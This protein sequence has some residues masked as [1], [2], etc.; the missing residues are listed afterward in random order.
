MYDELSEIYNF[1]S[2]KLFGYFYAEAFYL[3]EN[4]WDSL[5]R[6]Q[7]LLNNLHGALASLV[8]PQLH[9]SISPVVHCA[10]LQ[11]GSG[12]QVR[13]STLNEKF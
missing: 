3:L 9:R 5:D 13:D 1:T 6:R 4:K 12:I 2:L 7:L 8:A 10:L 11:G